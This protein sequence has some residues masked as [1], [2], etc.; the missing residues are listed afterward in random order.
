MGIPGLGHLGP[1]RA[2]ASGSTRVVGPGDNRRGGET[3]PPGGPAMGRIIRIAVAAVGLAGCG[4]G[5]VQGVR[6]APVT[7][8]ERA[9]PSGAEA[10][11]PGA[12]RKVPMH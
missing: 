3:G 6:T 11:R 2:G 5:E 4:R 10:P 8:V 7:G 1:A 12:V 9:A